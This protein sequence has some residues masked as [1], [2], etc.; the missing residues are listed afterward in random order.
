MNQTDIDKS[1]KLLLEEKSLIETE[2]G[3]IAQKNPEIKDDWIT[4]FAKNDSTDTLDEKAHSVT[5]FEEE[6]ALE[7]SLEERLKEINITLTKIAAGSYLQ[8]SNCKLP[9]EEKR[10]VAS[11]VSH[12]C[13]DCANKIPNLT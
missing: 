7:Q 1:R 12:L 4:V 13:I 6:R 11:P 9:I 3:K 5:E 8:C 10:L 2:L